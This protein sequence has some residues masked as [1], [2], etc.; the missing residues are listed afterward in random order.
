MK[1]KI[2]HGLSK[3][4][5]ISEDKQTLFI[6]KS[7]GFL[8]TEAIISN[9]DGT[10]VFSVKKDPNPLDRRDKYIFTE[11][12][13]QNEFYAWAENDVYG[14][15][16]PVPIRKRI[17]SLPVEIRVEAESFF[18]E[19]LI[20]R[21]SAFKFGI[22]INGKSC[23]FVTR[24]SIECDNIDNAGLLAVLYLFTNYISGSEELVHAANAK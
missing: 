14:G 7:K 12:S 20:K 6:I 17:F 19:L 23:G 1:L 2:K 16:T 13:T 15:N 10:P 21:S 9:P 11:H 8:G 24:R 4:F 18:G 22:F 3:K 5:I